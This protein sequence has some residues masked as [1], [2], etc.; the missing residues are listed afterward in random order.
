MDFVSEIDGF[1]FDALENAEDRSILEFYQD[2][3]VLVDLVDY[4]KDL[5]L[6]NHRESKSKRLWIHLSWGLRFLRGSG[7]ASDR[8]SLGHESRILSQKH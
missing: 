8:A 7:L 3:V 5:G 4:V 6:G 2:R 1:G